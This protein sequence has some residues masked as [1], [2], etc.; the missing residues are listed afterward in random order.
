MLASETVSGS[1]VLLSLAYYE[2]DERHVAAI[3]QNHPDGLD[4]LGWPAL[5][6]PADLCQFYLND[7]LVTL[8][9]WMPARLG[10]SSQRAYQ[11][12]LDLSSLPAG[13]HE[14]RAE[15][16][17]AWENLFRSGTELRRR[18]NWARLVFSK[19]EE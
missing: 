13:Q 6:H 14:L 5:N 11:C 3:N 17:I 18:E 12:L 7:S 2:E 1:T 9:G 15:K 8:T 4:T 19:L 10:S 16:L